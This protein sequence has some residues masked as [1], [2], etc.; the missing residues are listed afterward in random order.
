MRLA[1]ALDVHTGLPH[2]VCERCS[3]SEMMYTFE[4]NFFIR[5]VHVVIVGS[6]RGECGFENKLVGASL[7]SLF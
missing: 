7:H 3:L 4:V 5:I 6:G 2:S 1:T